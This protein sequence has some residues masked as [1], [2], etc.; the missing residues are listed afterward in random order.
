ME[1]TNETVFWLEQPTTL[2]SN[3]NYA[4]VIP[5]PNSTFVETLNDLTRLTLYLGIIVFVITRSYVVLVLMIIVIVALIVL[6]YYRKDKT[7]NSN[8]ADDDVNTSNRQ[9]NSDH[10]SSSHHGGSKHKPGHRN[11][12][13]DNSDSRDSS[14]PKSDHH[15]SKP[16]KSN[17]NFTCDDD[18][19][20]VLKNKNTLTN[21][22]C[23]DTNCV[24]KASNGKKYKL[25]TQANPNLDITAREMIDEYYSPISNYSHADATPDNCKN[26]SKYCK[27]P[28]YR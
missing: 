11:S 6:Y 13:S 17:K 18:G 2:F 7:A 21:V 26:N 12:D 15:K 4:Q 23:D 22:V 25:P 19:I 24:I 3:G 20:C 5:T 14:S 1:H 28:K 8:D 27:L 9:H 16:S 10:R